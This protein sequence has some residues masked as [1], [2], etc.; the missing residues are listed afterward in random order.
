MSD[1]RHN[2]YATTLMHWQYPNKSYKKYEFECVPVPLYV[3]METCQT[4][5]S[6]EL[7]L[8]I[9][10]CLYG[11][12]LSISLVISSLLHRSF[13]KPLCSF[14]SLWYLSQVKASSPSG[15]TGRK[16]FTP[17]HAFLTEISFSTSWSSFLFPYIFFFSIISGISCLCLNRWFLKYD[18]TREYHNPWASE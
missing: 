14:N 11:N 1:I 12:V 2:D 15:R 4:S 5:L 9:T 18:L 8:I 3:S 13:G 7:P 17:K 16:F 6:G 10:C